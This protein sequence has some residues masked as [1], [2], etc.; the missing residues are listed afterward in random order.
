ME[1]QENQTV[2]SCQERKAAL[3]KLANCLTSN[4]RHTWLEEMEKLD[5]TYRDRANARYM[6][7]VINQKG[8]MHWV[9][10]ESADEYDTDAD[11]EADQLGIDIEQ[12]WNDQKRW[13]KD[14]RMQMEKWEQ[15]TVVSCWE[16]K[17][18]L[19]KLANCLTSDE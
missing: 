12:E 18:A 1:K 16:R 11:D 7:Y 2:V 9:D 3:M 19:M 15:W 10:W 5:K 8:P 17:A 14:H 6:H 4:E 13:K